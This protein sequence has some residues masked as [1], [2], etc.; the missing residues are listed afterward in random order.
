MKSYV[1][2]NS[3]FILKVFMLVNKILYTVVMCG[4]QNF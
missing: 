4:G 2:K 1:R 3:E